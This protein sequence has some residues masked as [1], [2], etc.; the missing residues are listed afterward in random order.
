MT[1]FRCLNTCFSKEITLCQK[2]FGII[3]TS[4]TIS[5][6]SPKVW[7]PNHLHLSVASAHSPR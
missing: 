2:A 3:I 4:V 7:L 1:R 6:A 5:S